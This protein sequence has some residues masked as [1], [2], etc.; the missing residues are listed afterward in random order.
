MVS[1]SRA[2]HAPRPLTE[3]WRHTLARAVHTPD[4]AGLLF[5]AVL[6]ASIVGAAWLTPRPADELVVPAPVA[7]EIDLE[8]APE[9]ALA[10]PALSAGTGSPASATG[11]IPRSGIAPPGRRT[12]DRAWLVPPLPEA[13]ASATP[14]VTRGEYEEPAPAV[15]M[16]GSATSGLPGT[17]GLVW[18]PPGGLATA[19]PAPTTAPK[20]AVDRA[21]ADRLLAEPMK[22]R[23]GSLGL[24]LPAAGNVASTL[25]SSV[26]TALGPAAGNA[27]FLAIL[28]P[29]GRVMAIQPVA[30]NG[31]NEGAWWTAARDATARLEGRSFAMV[32]PFENGA[33]VWVDVT[34]TLVLPSGAP[35][36]V[37]P[38]SGGFRFDVADIGARRRLVVRTALRV[39]AVR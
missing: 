13:T 21:V 1:A 39:A 35:A 6:H 16:A 9:P 19:A 26:R 20:P 29:A 38:A 8:I 5:A 32:S 31:G 24:T 23:D 7:T 11:G 28:T 27:T 3:P 14:T 22:A 10:P 37:T 34:A 15:P 18:V 4:L 12:P 33:V 30:W 2:L 36:A 17:P 25:A